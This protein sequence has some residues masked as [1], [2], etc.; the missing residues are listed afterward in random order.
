MIAVILFAGTAAAQTP[1]PAP[2]R[3]GPSNSS[4]LGIV[5][6]TGNAHSTSVGLRNVYG[7]RFPQAEL[8][9]EAGWVRVSS[10]DGHRFAIGSPE[11]FRLVEPGSSVDSERLFSKVRYQQQFSSRT[12]WFTNFDAVR[13]EPAN[14][15]HQFVIAAGFGNTWYKTARGTFRT[16]YGVTVTDEDLVVEGPNRF[17]GYRLYYGFKTPL[18]GASTIESELTA[19]GSFDTARD[20]RADWLNGVSVPMNAKLALKS[21]VR[22]LFRNLPALEVLELRTAGGGPVG[23]VEVEK[24]KVDTNITTS[25]VIT[26]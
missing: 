23:E 22:L 1:P 16:A 4:D 25:L 24:G 13:D 5:I 26:F 3:P 6:A 11:A 15:S 18:A 12:D 2:P 19:D 10:R 7:Y 14:I 21:S 9:W 8:R 17:G 20:I